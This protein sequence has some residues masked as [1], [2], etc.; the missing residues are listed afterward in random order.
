MALISFPNTFASITAPT[1]AQLDANFAA[2]NTAFASA[3][4]VSATPAVNIIPIT[5]GTF[6]VLIGFTRQPTLCQTGGTNINFNTTNYAVLN[7]IGFGTGAVET[8]FQ[9]IMGVAGTIRAL[10]AKAATN[11]LN[12]NTVITLRQNA[13]GSTLTVTIPGSSTAV[14]NDTTHVVTFA[15]NDLLNWQIV[16][17]ASGS[18]AMSGLA[19]SALVTI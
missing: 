6:G 18:G 9:S 10:Y 13:A 5:D 14:V 16:T 2:I 8:G 11:T 4:G 17:T 3:T 19:I 7:G 1:G 12:S 15:V